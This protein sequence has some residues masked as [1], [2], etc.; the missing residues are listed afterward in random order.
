MTETTTNVLLEGAAWNFINIRRTTTAQHLNS[1]AAYRFARGIHPAWP[2]TACDVGA[3]RMPSGAAAQIA[4]GL[5]DTYP[6]PHAD[7]MVGHRARM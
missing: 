2:K 1:E 6:L 5:V 3:E 7:P 4:Q